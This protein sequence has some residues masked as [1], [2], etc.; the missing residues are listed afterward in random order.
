MPELSLVAAAYLE[1]GGRI[2]MVRGR[3]PE[4]P[5]HTYWSLPGGVAEP[6][7][8][9]LEAAAR[10]LQEETGLVAESFGELLYAVQAELDGGRPGALVMVQRV[11]SW[12]G[13]V[14]VADPDGQVLE[15]A[16]L[17]RAEAIVRAGT[18]RWAAMREP[19]VACLS[20]EPG[21]AAMWCYRP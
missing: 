14:H 19:L 16:F 1:A 12:S 5:S 6:G 10:E 18:I 9:V 11:L 20:G 3:D 4:D 15:A 17:P 21:E 8:L 2:L 7:E 13:D